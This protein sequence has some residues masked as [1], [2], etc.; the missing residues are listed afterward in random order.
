MTRL[1]FII[2]NQTEVAPYKFLASGVEAV[3][4]VVGEAS[5]YE[6]DVVFSD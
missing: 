3:E 6:Q 1:N 2:Q 4:K 5:Y